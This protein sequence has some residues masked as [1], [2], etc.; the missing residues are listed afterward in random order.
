VKILIFLAALILVV[1]PYPTLVAPEW[2]VL[3]VDGQSK[4]LNGVSVRESYQNY[5]LERTG[6]EV[7]TITGGDGKVLFPAKR[8]W[9]NLLLR[10]IGFLGALSGGVHASFGPHDYVMANGASPITNGYLED[11]TG[12]PSKMSSVIVFR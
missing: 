1:V 2:S 10:S 9:S 7:D 11:W 5:S 8:I 3:V 4:P 6:Y 12:R